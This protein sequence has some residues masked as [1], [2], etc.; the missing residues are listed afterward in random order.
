MK[1]P[2]KIDIITIFPE[3]FESV[4]SHSIIKR[5][6]EKK[7]VNISIHDLRDYTHDK[8]KKVDAPPY[9]GGPGMVMRPEPLFEAVE[10]IMQPDMERSKQRIIF[11]SPQGKLLSQGVAKEL[12]GYGQIIIICGRYEG[13]DER[14]I[15]SLIDDEI[16]IGDYVLS[17]GEIAAMAVVDCITRLVPGVLGDEDSA[18]NESFEDGLLDFPHYTRPQNFRGLEVPRVLLSGDHARIEEWRKKEARKKTE[19]KRPDLL[20]GKDRD[21]KQG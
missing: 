16:S 18:V 13:V 2:L 12:M 8:H 11:V 10:D 1:K 7:A 14:V 17:G 19:E 21:S 6:Q 20:K 9:G 3:M 15:T 5:A 4:F